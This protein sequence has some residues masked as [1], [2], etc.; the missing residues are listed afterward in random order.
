MKNTHHLG[1]IALAL[2]V[3]GGAIS[4]TSAQHRGRA[5]VRALQV[6]ENADGLSDGQVLRHRGGHRS[7]RSAITAQLTAAQ[8]SAIKEQI[9]ALREGGA[10]AEEISSTLAAEL[11]AAGVELPEG[12]ADRAATREARRTAR[13]AQREEIKSLVEG[14][15]ADGA[16]RA[17]I[18]QALQD[19]GY[20]KPQ[21]TQ[22]GHRG[23]STR[24]RAQREEIKSLVEG[25]KADGATRAEI[26]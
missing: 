16:T 19:A 18:R 17:E 2:I 14:M 7:D 20:Q 4:E 10:S 22:R 8:R 6:D 15:K 11:N 21:R 26:R 25:M 24:D 12:F 13:Q 3:A 23:N 5:N 9:G 1:A